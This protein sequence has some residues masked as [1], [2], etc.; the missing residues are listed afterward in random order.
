MIHFDV[1][2][3]KGLGHNALMTGDRKAVERQTPEE[4]MELLDITTLPDYPEFL[5]LPPGPQKSLMYNALVAQA[6]QREMDY[7]RY[8]DDTEPR[9]M[10]SQSSSF[11]G[12][13]DYDPYSN[14]AMVQ[15]GNKV[16]PYTGLDPVRMAEWLN[17]PSMEDYYQNF[18]KSK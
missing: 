8:W 16:Y 14:M 5:A 13:M 17:S 10:V 2:T 1:M 6:Q 4:H 11:I 7:P 18:I 9:R 12:P 3:G 15:M